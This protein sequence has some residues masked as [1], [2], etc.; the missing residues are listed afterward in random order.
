MIKPVIK[1]PEVL[2]IQTNEVILLSIFV[3]EPKNPNIYIINESIL[4]YK[5]NEE[6]ESYAF[7]IELYDKIIKEESKYTI[8]ST[9]IILELKKKTIEKWP[10]LIKEIK[11]YYWIK[12]DWEHYGINEKGIKALMKNSLNF[13]DAPDLDNLFENNISS[14]D[15]K[16]RKENESKLLEMLSNSNNEIKLKIIQNL[17]IKYFSS[18][19]IVINEANIVKIMEDKINEDIYNTLENILFKFALKAYQTST[20]FKERYMLSLINFF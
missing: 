20:D 14:N 8:S 17:I 6:S 4:S 5:S 19:D 10:R 16:K 18:S 12:P 3:S 1:I 13:D 7:E 2:W 15:E 9:K 11:K